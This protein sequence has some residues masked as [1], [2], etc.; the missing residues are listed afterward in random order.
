[1]AKRTYTKIDDET[2]QETE[3]TSETVTRNLDRAELQTKIDHWEQDQLD[4]QRETDKKMA[5][6]Q[7]DIDR[8]KAI[9][10]T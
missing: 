2:F 1:M 8:V 5:E 4:L 3:A 6:L 9:L 10:A 7:F